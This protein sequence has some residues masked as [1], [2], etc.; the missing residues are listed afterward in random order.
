MNTPEPAPTAPQP[1][2]VPRLRVIGIVLARGRFLVLVGGLLAL[3]AVWPVLQN[4]WDKFTRTAPTGGAI[5]SGTEY[6]CPM[7]PGVVSDWPAKCPV[8]NMTLVRREKGDMTPLPDGVVARLQLSPYRLQLAG[9]RT[10]AAEFVKLEHEVTAAG[11]LEAVPGAAA[12]SPLVLAADVFERDAVM[13]SVGQ[14]GQVACDACP[15]ETLVGRVA[16]VVPAAV[17]AVGRRVRVR[18]E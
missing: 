18:V 8:C 10:S 7:C 1:V 16:E 4:Y 5:S 17:P 3:V 6:W 12:A 14:E 9:A 11:F 13:L 15:G 2:P